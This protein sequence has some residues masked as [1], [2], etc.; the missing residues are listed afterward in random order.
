MD[1][2]SYESTKKTLAFILYLLVRQTILKIGT[3]FVI[4]SI[5]TQSLNGVRHRERGRINTSEAHSPSLESS[6]SLRMFAIKFHR[7]YRRFL[8][9]VVSARVKDKVIYEAAWGKPHK[10]IP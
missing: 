6:D 2:V 10:N 9:K 3:E 5:Q 8:Y 4:E 1:K 7:I